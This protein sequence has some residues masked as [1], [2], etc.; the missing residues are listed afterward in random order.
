MKPPSLIFHFLIAIFFSL[1]VMF[2]DSLSLLGWL[3]GSIETIFRPETRVL[4]LAATNIARSA[5][6]VRYISSGPA[7]VADLERRLAAAER[8]AVVSARDREKSA[9]AEVLGWAAGRNFSL[10]PA[11]VLSS[12]PQL[13][14]EIP[15]ENKCICKVVVSPD[16]A[17]VGEI[18]QIGRWSARVK[19][20]SD[21][22]S[23]ISAAVLTPDKQKLTDGIVVG[24]FGAAGS[25]E[26][27]LTEVD[28]QPDLTVVTS[29]QDDK[30]PSDI[31]IGWIGKTVP[32]QESSVYQTAPVVPAVNPAELKVV[33]IIVNQ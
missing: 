3:R 18:V 11:A 16:G 14:I 33:F 27:I 6:T 31:L 23:Q 26:K 30:F 13:I 9:A 4:S 8:E 17:L 20:L 29:G 24:S 5:A 15:P 10:I 22:Q 28:L 7:R 32:K 1:L 12:G 21:S 19:L 25:L 2:F